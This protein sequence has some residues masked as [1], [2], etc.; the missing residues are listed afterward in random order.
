MAVFTDALGRTISLPAPPERIVSLV[1][2]LTETLFALGLEARIVGV[3]RFCERPPQARLKPIV[4]GTKNPNV[5]RILSLKPDLVIA[6]QEENRQED[7]LA[8]E[9]RLPVYVTAIR[10]IPEALQTIEALGALT[11]T[12]ER[13]QSLIEDIQQAWLA[14]P[15]SPPLGRALYLIW[16]RPYMS[17]GRDTFT[18]AML[19]AAGWENVCADQTRYP[20]LEPETMQSLQPDFVLLASEPY[21]FKPE[22]RAEIQALL[23]RARILHVDGAMFSWYGVR[24]REA[25]PYLKN[26]RQQIS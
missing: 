22:H 20:V 8:L 12:A 9:G 17:V 3:T 23:P 19:E 15:T 1:P 5:E 4:G 2:S 26:L 11:D 10:T 6:N 16:R 13:A 21:R 24:M 25:F 7:I 14:L 18:H